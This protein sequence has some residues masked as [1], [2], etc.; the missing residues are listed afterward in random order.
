MKAKYLLSALKSLRGKRYIHRAGCPFHLE[1]N[2]I[3]LTGYFSSV[4]EA[5]EAASIAGYPAEPCPFCC[6][7][8]IHKR[9]YSFLRGIVTEPV[10]VTESDFETPDVFVPGAYIN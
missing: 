2:E 9:N 6:E 4:G 1:F 8:Y 5:I 3:L 10:P 7:E